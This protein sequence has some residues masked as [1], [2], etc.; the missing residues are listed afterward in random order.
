VTRL[1]QCLVL[2]GCL[3]V[4]SPAGAKLISF[5]DIDRVGLLDDNPK[6]IAIVLKDGDWEA[7]TSQ[8]GG[9]TWKIAQV[10]QLPATL[11]NLPTTGEIRYIVVGS[12]D[13]LPREQLF[14]RS[15]N[16]GHDWTDISPWDFL[17]QTLRDNMAKKQSLYMEIYGSWFS[18]G[19]GRPDVP[20][21]AWFILFLGSVIGWLTAVA[22]F[23]ASERYHLPELIL[24]SL[25]VCL[26]TGIGFCAIYL[27]YFYLFTEAQWDVSLGLLEYPKL[28]MG[29][30]LELTSNPWGAP[31]A[32]FICFSG[33]P[34]YSAVANAAHP[35]RTQIALKV[36]RVVLLLG[37][38]TL[39]VTA[40]IYGRGRASI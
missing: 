40:A 25:V 29:I 26:L 15:D 17:R 18:Y 34:L 16:A 36:I 12:P 13:V 3:L 27:L 11:K 7:V 8:D 19:L 31:L 4:A 39:V 2:V 10:V 33:T 35:R 9:R 20:V 6:H 22:I 5:G 28:P 23:C 1:I 21:P 38:V 37:L 30:L 24:S 32:A 14:I